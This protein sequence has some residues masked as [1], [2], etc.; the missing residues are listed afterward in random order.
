MACLTSAEVRASTAVFFDPSQIA[1]PVA[2]GVTW[3]TIGV[4]IPWPTGVEAQAVTTPPPG[5][6]DYKARITLSRVDGAVFDLIAFTAKLLANTGGAGAS[7]EIMPLV[8]GED[9]F[10]EPVFFN[11][12]GYYGSTFSYDE[13]PNYL[14]T[15][16]ALKGFDTYKIGLYVDFALTA[17][18]LEGP[19]ASG[20]PGDIDLSGTVDRRDAA[21]LSQNFGLEAGADWFA[22]DFDGDGATTLLDLAIL[23]AHLDPIAAPVAGDRIAAVPEPSA[24]LLVASGFGVALLRQLPRRRR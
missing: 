8:G 19:A 18:T 12:T 15:T 7:I 21:L 2:S 3:D 13:S 17:L 16:A 23:Q 14:G 24:A 1:T 4:R 20:M 6:T 22:G 10:D 5:V 9:A 11:A